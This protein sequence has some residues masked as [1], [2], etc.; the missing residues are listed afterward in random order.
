[1]RSFQHCDYLFDM[2]DFGMRVQMFKRRL[3]LPWILG[4]AKPDLLQLSLAQ[5]R[6]HHSFTKH[7]HEA[8]SIIFDLSSHVNYHAE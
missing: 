6:R 1:M 8:V 5:L 2:S 7:F 4:D 3:L